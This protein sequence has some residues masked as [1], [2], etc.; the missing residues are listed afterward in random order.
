MLHGF[1][2]SCKYT[3]RKQYQH[4]KIKFS[5]A[6]YVACVSEQNFIQKME[7]RTSFETSIK[8]YFEVLFFKTNIMYETEYRLISHI[9]SS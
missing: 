2:L 4:R 6:E 3:E 7:L 1:A 8:N 9:G 5:P